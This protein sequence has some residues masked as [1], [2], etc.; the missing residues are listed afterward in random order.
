MADALMIV[1]VQQ[2]MFDPGHVVHQGTEVVTRLAMLL[3]RARAAGAPV[4]HVQHD[5]GAGDRFARGAPGWVHHPSVAPIAGECVVEKRASS[6]FTGTDLHQRLQAT[7]FDRL[8]LCG[9]Q[10]DLCV[11]STLRG[12]VSYGL[13]IVLVADGHTTYDNPVLTADQI[14]AHHNH[15][16]KGRFAQ[17]VLAADVRFA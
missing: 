1:D 16:A 12:A 14:I 6:A 11:E 5:G 4:F 9:M 10:T 2:G 3:G 17:L 7:A 13:R 8:V 15:T